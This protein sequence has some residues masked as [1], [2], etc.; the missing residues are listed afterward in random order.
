MKARRRVELCSYGHGEPAS[1]VCLGHARPLLVCH[2]HA[3]AHRRRRCL[4]AAL[5][6]VRAAYHRLHRTS[7]R[8]AGGE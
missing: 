1:H 8:K 6:D 7:R 4:L 3:G 5:A 2:R